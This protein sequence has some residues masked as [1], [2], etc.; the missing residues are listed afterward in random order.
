MLEPNTG[1]PRGLRLTGC[2][3][4]LPSDH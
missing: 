1:V 4:L 3:P 2:W